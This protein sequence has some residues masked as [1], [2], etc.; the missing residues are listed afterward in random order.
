MENK[1]VSLSPSNRMFVRSLAMLAF[2]AYRG[3]KIRA[4]VRNSVYLEN[5]WDGGTRTCVK[6]IRLSDRTVHEPAAFTTNP[7]NGGAHGQLEIPAGVAM[8][9]HSIFCG[10]DV[11]LTV[12]FSAD[13]QDPGLRQFANDR[14]I[15]KA[16]TAAENDEPSEDEAPGAVWK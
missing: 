12:V 3:R 4:V 10:K 6:A 15:A 13:V 5:Y 11:G 7:M 8:V 2:P 1:V 14:D 16:L 9:E